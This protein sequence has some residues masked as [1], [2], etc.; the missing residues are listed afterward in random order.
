MEISDAIMVDK[1]FLIDDLCIEKGIELI[2]PPFLKNKIQFS[3][4][5]TL[6]NKDIACASIHIKGIN[7]RLKMFKIFQ[8]TF[9]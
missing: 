6:L 9:K 4:A 1:G 5:E 3:K 2:R 7:Q 8:N